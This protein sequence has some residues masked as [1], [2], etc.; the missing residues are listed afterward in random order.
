MELKV[1]IEKS[2]AEINGI[3]EKT[4]VLDTSKGKIIDSVEDL[5][6]ISEE[7]AASN[8]EVSANVAE[9]ISEVQMVNEHCEKMNGMADKLEESVAYFHE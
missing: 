3:N 2:L 5:S 6:A 8:Q 1:E 4:V 9:I 7:N